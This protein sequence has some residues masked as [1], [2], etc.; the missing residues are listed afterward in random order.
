QDR[1]FDSIVGEL[2][3]AVMDPAFTTVQQ[4]FVDE[5]C[6]EFDDTEENKLI[7]TDLF[8]QHTQLA[9]QHLEARLH[10]RI[11]GF[12]MEAFMKMVAEREDEIVG[13]VVDI[14]VA[15]TDFQEFKDMMVAHRK[16]RDKGLAL[17]AAVV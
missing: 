17:A 8:Q 10:Q 11:K 16:G 5:W 9:E 12:H 2:E 14:L 3:E 13:D 15:L 1:R 7:Y 6:G 4:A